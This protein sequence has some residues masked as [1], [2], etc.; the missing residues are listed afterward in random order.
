MELSS[1]DDDL[2]RLDL[3]SMSGFLKDRG[4]DS[5]A[6]SWYVNYACRDDYGCNYNDVSA[7]AG[8]HYFAIR[9]VEVGTVLTSTD[10]NGWIAKRLRVRLATRITTGSPLSHFSACYRDVYAL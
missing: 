3:I 8:I 1:R 4:L 10:G 6:L 2:L 5:P 9:D 7:W